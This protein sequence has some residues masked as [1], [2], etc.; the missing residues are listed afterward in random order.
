MVKLEPFNISAPGAPWGGQKSIWDACRDLLLAEKG[1]FLEPKRPSTA[2]TQR[3]TLRP[4]EVPDGLPDS[5][6]LDTAAPDVSPEA[7]PEE[8]KYSRLFRNPTLRHLPSK[9]SPTFCSRRFMAQMERPEEL[10]EPPIACPNPKLRL[11]G[12]GEVQRNMKP[13]HP[14]R[15]VLPSEALPL[16]TIGVRRKHWPRPNKEDVVLVGASL[17]N[18]ST[19][20]YAPARLAGSIVRQQQLALAQA[21]AAHR[22]ARKRPSTSG[23][24]RT[25]QRGTTSP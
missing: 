18:S 23:S 13:P 8:D 2:P 11:Q 3:R 21:A 9:P 14:C 17:A 19:P 4:S 25:P 5:P 20:R 16:E 22:A 7:A 15:V 12:E 1:R 6:R 24:A 10:A